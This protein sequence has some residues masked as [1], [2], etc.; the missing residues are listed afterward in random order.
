[1]VQSHR[2]SKTVSDFIRKAWVKK[3]RASL[4]LAWMSL[5]YAVASDSVA[6]PA[7]GSPTKNETLFRGQGRRALGGK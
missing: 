7:N 1:V 4:I 5:T 6:G 2:L 3:R